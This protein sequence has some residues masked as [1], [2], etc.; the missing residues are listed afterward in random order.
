MKE[1]A[2]KVNRKTS[3]IITLIIGLAIGSL[4]TAAIISLLVSSMD[5]WLAYGLIGI[6]FFTSLI[7]VLF[8]IF[9]NE[10]F[11][12]VF[13][14]KL[15]DISTLAH[16]VVDDI[17]QNNVHNIKH[18]TF[19]AAVVWTTIKTRVAFISFLVF[20]VTS[21]FLMLNAYVMFRQNDLLLKQIEIMKEE[22]VLVGEQ[23]KIATQEKNISEFHRTE[24]ILDL[25]RLHNNKFEEII[26][27][28][29]SCGKLYDDWGGSHSYLEIN[30]YLAFIDD[31][32][33][34][35][36]EGLFDFEKLNEMLGYYFLSFHRNN[37]GEMKR[38]IKG[39]RDNVS[40]RF[41]I[42]LLSLMDKME[43]HS[44]NIDLIKNIDAICIK[45]N[46]EG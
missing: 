19:E 5:L 12:R 16:D 11:E 8:W 37:N 41:Y 31:M 9:K 28:V 15:K 2:D 3:I 29:S 13:G 45:R 30:N 40:S 4:C 17:S 33:I 44:K 6:I 14:V 39:V 46:Q 32:A 7:F 1:V 34:Y 36:K 21:L 10:F 18:R 23:V 22:K 25:V 35:E 42:N 24:K 27:T 38:Y 26:S 20:L 43:S